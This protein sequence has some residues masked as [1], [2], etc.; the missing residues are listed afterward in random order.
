MCIRD[1][2][3]EDIKVSPHYCYSIGLLVKQ[4][5]DVVVIVP[6]MSPEN[7]E[8]GAVR[9][10]CGDMTIPMASVKSIDQLYT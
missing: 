10:G 3:I 2:E 7:S 1:R 4:T 8:N 5:D 9:S 6:H